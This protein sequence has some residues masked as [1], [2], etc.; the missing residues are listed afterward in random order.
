[1]HVDGSIEF[2]VLPTPCDLACMFSHNPLKLSIHKVVRGYILASVLSLYDCHLILLQ[3]AVSMH[4]HMLACGDTY[5]NKHFM[6]IFSC[7]ILL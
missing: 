5:S 7:L 2:L 6:H 4:A 3:Q 1:M